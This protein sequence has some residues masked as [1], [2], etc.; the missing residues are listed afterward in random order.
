MY[1]RKSGVKFHLPVNSVDLSSDASRA[2]SKVEGTFNRHD[3]PRPPPIREREDGGSLEYLTT[4]DRGLTAA[5]SPSSPSLIGA[6]HAS[7]LFRVRAARDAAS[8]SLDVLSAENL[9]LLETVDRLQT[10]LSASLASSRAASQQALNAEAA[11]AA[12]TAAAAIQSESV[13]RR[14]SSS[15]PKKTSSQET[16][17]LFSPIRSAAAAGGGSASKAGSSIGPLPRMLPPK[18]LSPSPR[19]L[20]SREA[21]MLTQRHGKKGAEIYATSLE[22]L[23]VTVST[24]LER[25]RVLKR[26][27]IVLKADISGEKNQRILSL[28]ETTSASA[29]DAGNVPA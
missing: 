21:T 17:L 29:S 23:T 24:I 3:T 9:S 19:R 13:A 28:G 10:E 5:T 15:T 11:V 22:L 7:E 12:A 1:P 18:G 2:S 25:L 8:E 26:R 27:E 20:T 16:G 4:Q 14:T 6:Q